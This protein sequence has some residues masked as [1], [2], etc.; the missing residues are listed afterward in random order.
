[1]F[2]VGVQIRRAPP[3]LLEVAATLSLEHLSWGL[4]SSTGMAGV[5]TGGQGM[6]FP[7]CLAHSWAHSRQRA[8]MPEQLPTAGDFEHSGPELSPKLPRGT[9][10]VLCT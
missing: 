4:M 7:Q 8:P 2:A 3:R 1:M 10:C 5:G 6:P 9:P